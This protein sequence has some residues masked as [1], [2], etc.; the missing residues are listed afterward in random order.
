MTTLTI[1][2]A[3]KE[4]NARKRYGNKNY[5]KP[6]NPE[7]SILLR[8]H[9]KNEI[10]I[11]LNG[12]RQPLFFKSGLQ[13]CIGYLRIV[14]SDYGAYVE[15]TPT[16]IIKANIKDRFNNRESDK[17]PVEYWW[18]IPADGSDCK[19]YEQVNKVAYADY[20]PGMFYVSVYDLFDIYHRPIIKTNYSGRKTV[21]L[22]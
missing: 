10:A 20:I 18:M 19:I 1:E 7:I 13:F 2:K 5:Y 9:Y 6:F 22:R 21:C 16:Q 17:R 14:I 15:C 11:S 3:L 4:C 8:T 12:G